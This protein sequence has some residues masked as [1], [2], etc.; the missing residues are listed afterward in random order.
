MS[1]FPGSER[2]LLL[3]RW[4]PI[5]ILAIFSIVLVWYFLWPHKSPGD[6]AS[7]SLPAEAL[8]GPIDPSQGESYTNTGVYH[9]LKGD[10]AQTAKWLRK[11]ALPPG[12]EP[13]ENPPSS[14]MS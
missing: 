6:L 14:V 8:D 9:F 11:A 12:V 4:S 13:I 7:K 2:R 1:E 10:K 3:E 5:G